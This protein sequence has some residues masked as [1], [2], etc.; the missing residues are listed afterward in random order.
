MLEFNTNCVYK[1]RNIIINPDIV[2]KE[3]RLKVYGGKFNVE[4]LREVLKIATIK[5]QKICSYT[6]NRSISRLT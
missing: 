2:Q 5:N 3:G 4:N 1:L 6:R